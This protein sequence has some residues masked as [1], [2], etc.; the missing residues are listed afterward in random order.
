[1]KNLF[2]ILVVD[3]DYEFAR[4]C[5][6]TLTR[7]GFKAVASAGAIEALKL[8]VSPTSF[9]L[10]LSD[11]KM[12]E[13]D[14]LEFL[15]RI[16]AIAPSLE[17]IILTGYGTIESAVDAI[18]CGAGN[19]VTKPVDKDELLNAVD[20]VY[21]VWKL[22]NEVAELKKTMSRKLELEGYVFKNQ[23]MVT[24]YDKVLSAAQCDCSVL[25]TGES[26]TG[27]EVLARTIHRNSRRSRGPFV[28]V[29][30][31]ALSRD[32]IE[33]ELFGY[34]KGA[35]TGANQDHDGLF[36][37]A[38]GGT[39]FLDE[40]ADMDIATQAKLL[41]SIQEHTVRPVGSIQEVAVDL[42]IVAA[43]NRDVDAALKTGRLREDL[44]HRLNVIRIELPP[45]RAMS[46]EIPALLNYLLEVK[47]IEHERPDCSFDE[48]AAELL[49]KYSWQG[50]IREAIN[51][52]ERCLLNSKSKVITPKELP[53]DVVKSAKNRLPENDKVP[54]MSEAERE[55]VL[56][57]LKQAGGN[58][59]KAA[60]MLGISRPRLYKKIEIYHLDDH[61]M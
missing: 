31:S 15:R 61:H 20:K 14:G 55:L 34:R 49:S 46:S 18:K 54:R 59:S 58:K 32:L 44:Y 7:A 8:I 52:V 29:N 53:A 51:L 48:A 24:I 16:K 4:T 39:L 36:V 21:R 13:V 22:E 28:P 17:V 25:L 42:R 33:S 40:V 45:L 12:P 38:G 37:A 5:A 56:R 6:R 47:A 9:D 23:T 35:F 1:M 19:Y 60:E 2:K 27:K 57:A 11:L 43:T 10:V 26:G 3:D 50:N 30:C 41:R